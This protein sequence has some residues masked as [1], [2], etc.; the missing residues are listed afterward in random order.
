MGI[1][2]FLLA[3]AVVLGHAPGWGQISQFSLEPIRPIAPY[4]AVQAFFVISGFY[5]AMIKNRYRDAGLWLFWSN[6][7]SRLIVSYLIVVA[8]TLLLAAALPDRAPSFSKHASEGTLSSSLLAFS[9]FTIFATDIIAFINRSWID[10]LIIPQ[11]WS[12]SLE[13]WFYLLVPLFWVLSSR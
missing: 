11:S 8:L 9:N 3:A 1:L 13:L 4:Y 10:A 12:L 2:R 6:R 7:Y 5:M